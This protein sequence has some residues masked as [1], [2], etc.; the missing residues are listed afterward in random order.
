M[1]YKFRPFYEISSFSCL[2]FKQFLKDKKILKNYIKETK[3]GK[4]FL[5]KNLKRLKIDFFPTN[6]NFILVK[7]SSK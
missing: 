3:V 2:V 6:T 1:L 5:I 4:N 7:L